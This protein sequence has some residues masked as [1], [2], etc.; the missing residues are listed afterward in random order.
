MNPSI[1]DLYESFNSIT[2]IDHEQT[3]AVEI[4]QYMLDLPALTWE[5]AQAHLELA[6]YLSDIWDLEELL[7]AEADVIPEMEM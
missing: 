5:G 7:G 4:A 6:A 2:G 3:S 1:N